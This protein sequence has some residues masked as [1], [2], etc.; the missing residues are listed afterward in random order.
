MK[1]NEDFCSIEKIVIK[2][3]SNGKQ[4]IEATSIHISQFD[5]LSNGVILCFFSLGNIIVDSKNLNCTFRSEKKFVS[6]YKISKLGKEKNSITKKDLFK[7][8]IREQRFKPSKD[9]IVLY[10]GEHWFLK[11]LNKEVQ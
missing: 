1:G 6:E 7:L 8:F 3:Y 5:I 9:P 4:D 10:N 2:K 11:D